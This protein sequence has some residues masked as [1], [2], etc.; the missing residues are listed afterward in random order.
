MLVHFCENM[1]KKMHSGGVGYS[2]RVFA[3]VLS[4]NFVFIWMLVLTG[5]F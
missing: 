2:A 3:S 5:M 1:V 4:E